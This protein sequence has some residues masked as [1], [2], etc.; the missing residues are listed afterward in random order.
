MK[1]TLLLKQKFSNWNG[2]FY[3]FI[4][5]AL[6][7]FNSNVNAQVVET[8]TSPTANS[9]NAVAWSTGTYYP[10]NQYVYAVDMTTVP[11]VNRLYKVLIAGTSTTM[12]TA[13]LAADLALMAGPNYV[14]MGLVAS[15]S[16]TWTCPTGVNSIQVECWGAGGAGGSASTATAG[17]R[18]G[19]GG[20]AG[21][22]VKKTIAVLPGTTYNV[23]V[24][25]GGYKGS[26]LAANGY[27]GNLGGRSEF[28]G[29][30]IAALVASGGTGGSGAGSGNLNANPGGVLGGVYGFNMTGTGT[31]YTSLSV[32]TLTGGGGSGVATGSGRLSGATNYIASTN[33]GTGYTSNPSVSVSIGAGQSFLAYANPNINSTGDGITTILGS[34]GSGS[35]ASAGGAG[36]ISPDGLAGGEGGTGS[37]VGGYVGLPST[38]VG[39]G[40][41]GGFSFYGAAGTNAS[42]AGG[43]GANGK[44]VITYT[45]PPITTYTY[46][47]SGDLHDVSNWKDGSNNAPVD[48][49]SDFQ[50][51][52]INSNATTT[53]PWIV[54]GASSKIVVGDAATTNVTLTIAS[55]SGITATMDVTN[56]NKVYVQDIYSVTSTATPPVTSFYMNHP[57]FGTLEDT[58]EVHY[59]NSTANNALVKT[60]FTYGKLYI[61]GNGSGTVFFSGLTNPTNHIVKILFEVAENSNALFSEVSYYYMSLN[62]GASANIYGTLKSGK[63]AGFVSSNVGTAASTFGS[64]QFI[65]SEALTLGANSTIE[66]NRTTSGSTQTV[67]PRT[68]YI[69]LIVSGLDNNKSFTGATTVSGTLTLTITGTSILSGAI[70]LTLGNGAT[71]TRTS[72]AFD[73]APNFGTTTNIIYDGTTATTS[74]F[75]LPTSGLNNLT[76]NNAAGVTLSGSN[77]VNGVLN[78][79]SGKLIT[80][81]NSLTI[82]TSGSITGAGA[83]TGWVVG[84]L[85]KQTATDASPSF[86]YAI[87]DATNYTPISLTFT[88]NNTAASTGSI[89]AT[90]TAGDHPQLGT[91][92]LIGTVNRTWN[93]SNNGVS[94]FTNYTVNLNYSAAETDAGATPASFVI[95]KYEGSTWTSPST[96]GAPSDS[97][98]SASGIIGFGDFAVGQIVSLS[99]S[100]FELENVK[101]FPNPVT[102]NFV[103]ISSAILED[104]N[105]A[106]FDVLGKQISSQ[107]LQNNRLDVSGLKS[108]IY[109]LKISQNEK[110]TTEKLVIK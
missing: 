19:G 20:G 5:L 21:S 26:T 49:T 3:S 57:T 58:S 100:N 50:L 8:F 55:G 45:A 73:V 79:V 76:V 69:N 81:A 15:F 107:K 77:T 109:L 12:P 85:I 36:G 1:L 63:V 56:G 11:S 97:S 28:S 89:T 51:F 23:I 80:D 44:I 14:Y 99:T 46:T 42:A 41:G 47:G 33:Q 17:T 18:S 75:E 61:D 30:A 7:L 37:S 82:G 62:S 92:D 103:T 91:S 4:C 27:Y 52:K 24:G 40:G 95:R 78:F 2:T 39:A 13:T 72:G 53:A 59:Q 6:L 66:Y 48:F 9:L 70:N 60:A 38:N 94:G 34:N 31:G 83:G 87:G 29:G 25:Q 35:S 74:S 43:A 84:N 54:S 101:I 16:S 10:V 88:G 90:T 93:L 104:I 110:T 108:G 68:D 67:T 86:A 96:L 102:N 22:Y 106:V 32:V 71:I 98:I 105:V 65:E 64:L